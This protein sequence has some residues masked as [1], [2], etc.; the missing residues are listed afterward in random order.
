MYDR[1][2]I[3]ESLVLDYDR[4]SPRLTFVCYVT[5]DDRKS[6]DV[7]LGLLLLLVSAKFS[8]KSD[9]WGQDGGE[10]WC[11]VSGFLLR[12]KCITSDFEPTSS[13]T[14]SSW[15]SSTPDSL[16]VITLSWA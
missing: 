14:P 16:K 5:V 11:V 3:P 8:L 10:T 2:V 13:S 7:I 1:Q 15:R 9:V 12:V 4:M 6:L